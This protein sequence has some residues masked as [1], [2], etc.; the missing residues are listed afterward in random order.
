MGSRGKPANAKSGYNFFTSIM[1]EEFKVQFPGRTVDFIDFQKKCA[2]KWK[3]LTAEQ[4]SPF[5]NMAALDKLRFQEEV[6]IFPTTPGGKDKKKKKLKDPNEPKKPLSAFFLFSNEKRLAVKAENAEFSIGEIGKKLG[7]MWRGMSDAS[8]VPFEEAAKRAKEKYARAMEAFKEGRP[9]AEEEEEEDAAVTGTAATVAE[10]PEPKAADNFESLDLFLNDSLAPAASLAADPEPETLAEEETENGFEK[11]DGLLDES[12]RRDHL[13]K[14]VNDNKQ[15]Y[16][17]K[18]DKDNTQ[19]DIPETDKAEN[20]DNS[21]GPAAEGENSVLAGVED[22][23]EIRNSLSNNPVKE[24]PLAQAGRRQTEV[25]AEAQP[26]SGTGPENVP[27]ERDGVEVDASRDKAGDAVAKNASDL[28][29]AQTGE[30]DA[31]A[32][33]G[34]DQIPST[35]SP[36]LADETV[37]AFGKLDEC[38]DNDSD[39]DAFDHLDALL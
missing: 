22:L 16:N 12:I 26:L 36:P 31:P 27:K 14:E 10:P 35:K 7:E 5:E 21:K 6:K 4:K 1:H 15:D 20:E 30:A 37:D 32:N 33:A 23:S 29:G 2:G 18:A 8:K 17:K 28:T 34:S 3:S 19:K 11:L 39:F 9:F 24:S 25:V 13:D 38:L